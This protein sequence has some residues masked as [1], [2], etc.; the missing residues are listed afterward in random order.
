VQDPKSKKGLFVE[1]HGHSKSTV[2]QDIEDSLDALCLGRGIDFGEKKMVL[3]GNV[4]KDRPVC[5]LVV[6]VY[7]ATN[8]DNKPS[9]F[10]D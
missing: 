2:K 9:F 6:A 3:Q 1:H 10:K 4:C 7:Q 8:W 5:A